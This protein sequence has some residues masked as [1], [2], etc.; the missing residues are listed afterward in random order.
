[1]PLRMRSMRWRI[2]SASI[3]LLIGTLALLAVVLLQILRTTYLRTLEA[4]VAGQARLVATIAERQ[5][6][7][8][9]APD[10]AALVAALHDE[11]GARITL[12]APDGTVLADAPQT[13]GASANLSARPEVRDALASGQGAS[14]RASVA[15]GEDTFYVAVPIGP[16]GAPAGVAR[17]GVPLTTIAQAQTRL[18]IAVLS[19]A[20]LAILIA[21]VLAV[22]IARRTTRPLLELR[23]M[24]A[25][26]AGGDLTVQVP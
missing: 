3:L 12:I 6:L 19:A 13:P 14:Q 17:I 11:L 23:T 8:T 15:N 25:R 21:L 16:R 2:A 10:R 22:L 20:L 4:G 7:L 26:L 5:N 24:A 18:G 1:M 9:A